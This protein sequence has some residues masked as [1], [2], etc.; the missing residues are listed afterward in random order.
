VKLCPREEG[1]ETFVLCRS[2]ARGLKEKG[3]QERFEANIQAG[4]V[5]LVESCDKRKRKVSAIERRIGA[6]LGANSRAKGLFKVE[7]NTGEDGGARVMWE[8]VESRVQSAQSRVGC[9]LLR[10]NIEDWDAQQLWQT[11]AQLVQAELAF[12]IQKDDLA[13]RPI[14]HQKKERV[15][16]HILV[17]FLAYVLWK[18]IGQLCQ[19]AGL[20]DEPRQV[21]AEVSQ[22]KTVDVILPTKAGIEIRRRCISEPTNH[23]AVL[24]DKLHLHLPQSLETPKV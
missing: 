9:Y 17:C 19:R 16:A 3:I 6:L 4:L 13:I 18:T 22:I 14:W 12:R 1:E 8:K 2:A 20:G 24:L 11:Y 7:V 23:Q 10:S 21:L 5:K 15:Q